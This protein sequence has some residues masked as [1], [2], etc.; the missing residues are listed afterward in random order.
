MGTDIDSLLEFVKFT[1]DIRAVKRSM[2]VRGENQLEND[3]EHS[4]Q[5]AMTALYLI[6]HDKLELDVFRAMAMALVH[7]ILEVHSGDTYIYGSGDELASKAEREAEAVITLR[8]QWPEL[9]L[10]HELIDEY[11][12]RE[13]GE[14]KFVYALDKLLPMANN[15]LDNGRSWKRESIAPADGR[16]PKRTPI[17]VERVIAAKA[18]KVSVDPTVNAYYLE[19]IERL[20]AHPEIFKAST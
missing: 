5:V 18:G 19:L 17:T 20:K 3:S 9:K 16:G 4:Y 8:Q 10:M 12:A 11:E 1:H 14:S 15:Y 7:D 6:E 2:L 13:T